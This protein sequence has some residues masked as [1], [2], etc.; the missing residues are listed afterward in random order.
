ML[1]MD[2]DARQ[3]E[4]EFGLVHGEL[5]GFE[6]VFS[7]DYSAPYETSYFGVL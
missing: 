1:R 3:I 2:W 5:D 6:V 7:K 4:S